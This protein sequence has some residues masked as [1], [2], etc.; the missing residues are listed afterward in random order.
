MTSYLQVEYR[1]STK[2]LKILDIAYSNNDR[3]WLHL[4]IATI[5]IMQVQQNRKGKRLLSNLGYLRFVH[6][7]SQ[8]TIN[9]L[10]LMYTGAYITKALH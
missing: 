4:L 7:E 9:L 10:Y 2:G 1:C 5:Q 6:Y 3:D 8:L